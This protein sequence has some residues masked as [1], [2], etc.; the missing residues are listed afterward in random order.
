MLPRNVLRKNL[1]VRFVSEVTVLYMLP[2]E[3]T[4]KLLFIV[5]LI[6]SSSPDMEMWRYEENAMFFKRE[7]STNRS[8]YSHM[9]FSQIT[10]CKEIHPETLP[11]LCCFFVNVFKIWQTKRKGMNVML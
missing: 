9:R 6:D 7:I 5:K 10:Y 4:M 1:R 2:D 8:I 3:N 11:V